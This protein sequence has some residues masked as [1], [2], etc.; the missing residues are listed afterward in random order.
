L[1]FILFSTPARRSTTRGASHDR[2]NPGQSAN[3]DPRPMP[4]VTID[5]VEDDAALAKLEPVWAHLLADTPAASGFQS[6]AWIA[7][8]RAMISPRSRRLF[9]LVVRDG[10]EV[11]GIVPTELDAGGDLCFV[12]DAVADY[13]G[14][15]YRRARVEDVVRATVALLGAERR[16]TLLDLQ[17]LREASPFVASLRRDE[18]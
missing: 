15:V 8:C 18:G 14:P 3:S 5:L 16:V 17:G 12:G 1:Q 6:F 4:R 10:S 13:S 7:T 2:E 9:T 11:I